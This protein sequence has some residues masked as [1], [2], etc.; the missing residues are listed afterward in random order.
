PAFEAAIA[1]RVR[2]VAPR[3]VGPGR[4]SPQHPQHAIEHVTWVAPRPSALR[5]RHDALWI[6]NE[7]ANELPLLVCQVHPDGRSQPR[8]GV[9]PLRRG[10]EMRSSP[11]HRGWLRGYARD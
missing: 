3:D 11:G 9:D 6:G 7:R 10:Y 1:S 2:R 8:S 4:A 5:A